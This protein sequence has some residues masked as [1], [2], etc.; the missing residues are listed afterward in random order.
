[1]AKTI[2]YQEPSS[3]HEV[4]F[5]NNLTK[6]NVAISEEI[7]SL[8]KNRIW[9]L[10]K[11]PKGQKIVGCKWVFKKKEGTPKVEA[12]RFNARLVAKGYSHK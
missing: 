5:S 3:Y 2:E 1:V 4:V 6:W 7:E 11:P 9:E 8:P 10:V 12:L